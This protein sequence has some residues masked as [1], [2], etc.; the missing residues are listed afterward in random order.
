[1]LYVITGPPAAGKSSYI[2]SH[3][4]AADIVIDMDLMALAMS[5][6]GADHH[7]HSDVLLAIVQ[8]ARFAAIREATQHLD[9]TDVYLIQTL[10]TAKHRAEY[11]RLKAKLVTIDP[12]RDVVMRRIE[13]MRQPAMKAV[14]TKWYKANRGRPRGA[15][16]QASWEW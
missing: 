14:A 16:P 11:R 2:Q 6:P 4:K 7:N 1:M 12:G 9:T 8:R 3:A 10:P 15:M 13:A 5:G